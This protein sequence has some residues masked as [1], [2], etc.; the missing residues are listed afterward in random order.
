MAE[1]LRELWLFLK[2]RKKLWMAPIFIIMLLCGSLI[3]AAKGSP[4]G[5]FI[6]TIF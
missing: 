3:L 2:V 4:L 1:F 6:Y 5:V